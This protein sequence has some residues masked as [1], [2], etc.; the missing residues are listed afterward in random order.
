MT[1][2]FR[3]AMREQA[4]SPRAGLIHVLMDA[5]VDGACLDDDEVIA[6]VIVTLA[7]GQESPSPHTGRL[8]PDDVVLGG[9]QIRKRQAIMAAG[10][11]DPAR[12][13]DPDRLDLTRPNNRSLAFGWAAHFCFGVPLARI[14]GQIALPTLPRR[15]PGLT[16]ADRPLV[17]HENLGLRGLAVLPVGFGAESP[18]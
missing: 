16:L 11:R 5:S 8:A 12:F 7:G 6:N 9:K 13:D 18:S 14:E 10:S 17:W 15:L 4:R 2:Y 3:S 1:A